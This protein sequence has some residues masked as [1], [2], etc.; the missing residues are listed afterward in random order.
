MDCTVHGVTKSQ[1]RLSNCHF[2]YVN[3]GFPHPYPHACHT[4]NLYLV[5]FAALI[6]TGQA[7][8]FLQLDSTIPF[9]VIKWK[10]ACLRV[11]LLRGNGI[12]RPEINPHI[13]GQFMYDKEGKNIKWIRD[14][15]FNMRCWENWTVTGKRMRLRHF[16]HIIYKNKPK[17]V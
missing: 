16:L 4:L 3:D 1:T 7:P 11:K 17:V 14:S 8:Y 5:C 9:S 13:Y 15:F 6:L 10:M 12:G 2:T